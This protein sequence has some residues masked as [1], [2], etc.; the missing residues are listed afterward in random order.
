MTAATPNAPPTISNTGPQMLGS[1][2][3]SGPPELFLPPGAD[4]IGEA[5]PPGVGAVVGTGVGTGRRCG[6]SSNEEDWD[7]CMQCIRSYI[8]GTHSYLQLLEAGRQAKC[9][10]DHTIRV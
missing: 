7:S 3:G 9:P 5:V 8:S 1:R 4:D 2:E 10:S 6:G